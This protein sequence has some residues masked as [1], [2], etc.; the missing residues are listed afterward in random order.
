M[1]KVV[2]K[3]Q[4]LGHSP[5]DTWNIAEID[6]RSYKYLPA[7]HDAVVQMFEKGR[8]ILEARGIM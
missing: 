6:A 4:P 8:P 7:E 2:D 5:G 3:Y 1:Q